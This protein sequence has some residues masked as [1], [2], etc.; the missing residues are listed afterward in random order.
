[1]RSCRT[2]R[3]APRAR[4]AG[5]GRALIDAVV[6]WAVEI[7]APSIR[8]NVADN[9]VDASGLYEASGFSPTGRTKQYENR[10]HLTTIELEHPAQ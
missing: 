7:G 1:L 10:P 5:V 2:L 8:L 4:R 9:N 3:V 6:T